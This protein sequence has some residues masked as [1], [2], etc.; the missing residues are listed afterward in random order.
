MR[1][2]GGV[3]GTHKIFRLEVFINSSRSRYNHT[4]FLPE[5]NRILVAES[6]RVLQEEQRTKE[7]YL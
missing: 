3:T 4:I 1:R 6:S 7:W 5:L 2:P